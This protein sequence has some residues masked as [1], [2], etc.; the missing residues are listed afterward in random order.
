[1]CVHN[2]MERFRPRARLPPN[3]CEEKNCAKRRIVVPSSHL[4]HVLLWLPVRKTEPILHQHAST[5]PNLLH[6]SL[7][8]HTRDKPLA[9]TVACTAN[10]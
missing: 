6:C 8:R 7:R 3:V 2:I 10:T 4:R 1:M 9:E 5:G